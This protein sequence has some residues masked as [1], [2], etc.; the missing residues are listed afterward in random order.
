[1]RSTVEGQ[2][3]SVTP[4]KFSGW[5]DCSALASTTKAIRIQIADV[6]AWSYIGPQTTSP[7]MEL[8]FAFARFVPTGID[9]TKNDR[10]RCIRFMGLHEFGHSL[11]FRHEQDAPGSTCTEG[12]DPAYQTGGTALTIYDKDSVMNYCAPWSSTISTA[13][14]EGL[15]KAYPC[16]SGQSYCGNACVSLSTNTMNCGACG[17][18]CGTAYTCSAGSCKRKACASGQILCLKTDTCMPPAMYSKICR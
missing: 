9:C 16:K 11:G 5:G 13:D 4:V 18:R 7:S 6:R 12:V 1:V 3:A 2:W 10:E 8:N 15:K 17:R 14:R